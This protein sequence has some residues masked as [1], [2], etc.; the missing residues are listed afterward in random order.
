MAA[1]TASHYPA[2]LRRAVQ[3]GTHAH[4]CMPLPRTE[5]TVPS[6]TQNEALNEAAEQSGLSLEAAP[7]R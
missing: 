5:H 2:E 6:W 1:A 3:N 4:P 7:P